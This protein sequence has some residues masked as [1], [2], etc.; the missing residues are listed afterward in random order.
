ME[1]MQ[2]GWGGENVGKLVV[3]VF[4]EGVGNTCRMSG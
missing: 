2:D 3:V 4:S 1:M